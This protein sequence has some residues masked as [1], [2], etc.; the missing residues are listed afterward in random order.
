MFE[1]TFWRAI[2]FIGLI[3]ILILKYRN[4][5]DI[6]KTLPAAVIAI[7]FGLLGNIA[8]VE[9]NFI[10]YNPAK[11]GSQVLGV[12]L[13]HQFS[14]GLMAMLLIHFLPEEKKDMP[15]YL[16]GFALIVDFIAYIA[17]Q[18]NVIKFIQWGYITNFIFDFLALGIVYYSYEFVR[19]RYL[20]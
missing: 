6:I 7:V 14:T 19:K 17:V 13:F 3:M 9:L 10:S 5:L 18:L 15:L 20:T 1:M 8:L 4:G 12:S 16:A 11:L 2:F